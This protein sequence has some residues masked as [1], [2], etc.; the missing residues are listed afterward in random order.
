MALY[1]VEQLELIRRLKQTG[2]SI[3]QLIEVTLINSISRS[4]HVSAAI[5]RSASSLLEASQNRV[6]H[7]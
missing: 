2:I 7:Y 4:S 5:D 1:T 6:V 3:E